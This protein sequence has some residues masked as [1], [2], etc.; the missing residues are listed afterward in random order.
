MTGRP[1]T[2]SN[3]QRTEK[4][5]VGNVSRTT[6]LKKEVTKMATDSV[7]IWEEKVAVLSIVTKLK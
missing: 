4:E 7:G 1:T 6:R 3:N 2:F 5:A